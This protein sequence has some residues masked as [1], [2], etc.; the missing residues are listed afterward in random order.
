M[1]LAAELL[2]DLPQVVR[3]PLDDVS[4]FLRARG[5]GCRRFLTWPRFY[6]G[7]LHALIGQ[8]KPKGTIE[9]NQMKPLRISN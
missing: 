5:L 3:V 8:P 2:D 9:L 4:N 6:V 7:R 1:E